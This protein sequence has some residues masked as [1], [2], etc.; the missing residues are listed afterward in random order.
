MTVYNKGSFSSWLNE[1]K[2]HIVQ[3]DIKLF[4]HGHNYLKIIKYQL[5]YT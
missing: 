2:P 4:L 3:K 1:F 5:K